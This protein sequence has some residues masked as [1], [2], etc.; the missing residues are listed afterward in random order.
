VV[1]WNLAQVFHALRRRDLCSVVQLEQLQDQ[2][3]AAVALDDF[4]AA[5]DQVFSVFAAFHA[6]M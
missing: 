4:E 6:W 1:D 3:E 2:K 5:V